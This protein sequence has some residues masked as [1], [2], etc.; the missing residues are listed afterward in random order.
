LLLC[1]MIF[2]PAPP[3]PLKDVPMSFSLNFLRSLILASILSFLMPVG[4]LSL[5]LTGLFLSGQLPFL[6][7]PSQAALHQFL[8][9]LAT[10]GNG[11]AVEGLLVI[12]IVGSFVGVLFDTF[13][14]YQQQ[15]LH[16]N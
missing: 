6:Q 2:A 8:Q 16:R 5:L 4:F 3:S 12:G 14:L 10:F 15:Y 9:F 1:F 13:V 7:T 11:D